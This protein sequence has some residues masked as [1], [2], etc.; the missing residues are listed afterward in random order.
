MAAE[1][2]RVSAILRNLLEQLPIYR[3][4]PRGYADSYKP[5]TDYLRFSNELPRFNS[6]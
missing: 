5:Y 1:P 2:S 6:K 4:G 3:A